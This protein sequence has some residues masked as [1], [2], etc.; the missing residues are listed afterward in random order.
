MLFQNKFFLGKAEDVFKV[1]VSEVQEMYF[2]EYFIVFNLCSALP[3][4]YFF[5]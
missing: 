1:T 4:H 5:M 3:S 2:L